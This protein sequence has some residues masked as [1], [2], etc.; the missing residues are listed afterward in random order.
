MSEDRLDLES[1]DEIGD[2]NFENS[3]LCHIIIESYDS[4]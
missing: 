4:K 3:V 1:D 2:H